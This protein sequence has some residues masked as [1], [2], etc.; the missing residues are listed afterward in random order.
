MDFPWFSTIFHSTGP[1]LRFEPAAFQAVLPF[2]RWF[3]TAW[4]ESHSFGEP[5]DGAMMH[6]SQFGGDG[7][8]ETCQSTWSEYCRYRVNMLCIIYVLIIYIYTLSI[9]TSWTDPNND[10][11]YVREMSSDQN[12]MYSFYLGLK[13][14]WPRGSENLQCGSS[15]GV[16]G[17]A[18]EVNCSAG[19]SAEVET[20]AAEV[21]RK[22]SRKTY[23]NV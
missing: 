7:W 11:E 2:V 21:A 4:G 20:V 14:G 17:S 18:A 13:V 23:V 10:Q 12:P 9:F 22:C 5:L 3:F 1:S 19:P 6:L 16:R 8:R 15:N